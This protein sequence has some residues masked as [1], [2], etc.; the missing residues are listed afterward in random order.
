MIVTG[1]EWDRALRRQGASWF[2]PKK[3]N[4]NSEPHPSLPLFCHPMP[5]TRSRSTAPRADPFSFS[6]GS[7]SLNFSASDFEE[8]TISVTSNRKDK[9]QQKQRPSKIAIVPGEIIEISD[10]DDDPPLRLNSQ[11]SMVGDLRRQINK[12]REVCWWH[13]CLVWYD[14]WRFW[15]SVSSFRKVSSTRKI[16]NELFESSTSFVKKI[17][18]CKPFE[19]PVL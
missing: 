12:L 4:Y 9:T 3:D 14:L 18:N 6:S 17:D 11:A 5:A 2:R 7:D 15:C 10:D 16:T 8:S 1:V 13:L 19:S